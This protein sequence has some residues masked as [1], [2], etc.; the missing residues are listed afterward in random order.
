MSDDQRDPALPRSEVGIVNNVE[1]NQFEW[2]TGTER[3]ILT[4]RVQGNVIAYRHTVVPPA[5]RNRRIAAAL[6]A[7]AVAHARENGLMVVPLCPY[8]LAYL[9]KH[10]EYGDL[11]VP[12]SRWTEVLDGN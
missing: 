7:H 3:A 5:L 11:V 9:A 1:A 4:Y 10:P 12:R 8:V 2:R 6:A